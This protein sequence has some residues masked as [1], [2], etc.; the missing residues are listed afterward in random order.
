[1]E[2]GR[3]HQRHGAKV[4]SAGH[5]PNSSWRLTVVWSS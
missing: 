2:G 5:A 1:V 3:E 4:S